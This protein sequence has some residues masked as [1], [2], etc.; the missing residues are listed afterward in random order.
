[1]DPRSIEFLKENNI[2][3]IYHLPKKINNKMIENSDLVLAMDA[4]ILAELNKNFR[5][6]SKKFKLFSYGKPLFNLSDPYTF[7]KD[8]YVCI[9]QNIKELSLNFRE[10]FK[11]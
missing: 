10:R 9:M 4:Y 3:E 7:S 8:D 6:Y 1:M 5:R 2:N 11:I